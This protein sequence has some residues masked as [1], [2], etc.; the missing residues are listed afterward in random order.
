MKL[1]QI[2]K[3]R[4]NFICP[5]FLQSGFNMGKYFKVKTFSFVDLRHD[6]PYF[7]KNKKNSITNFGLLALK[8]FTSCFT[9]LFSASRQNLQ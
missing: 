4:F 6:R 1:A 7:S 2:L 8:V 5:I 9:P 3:I